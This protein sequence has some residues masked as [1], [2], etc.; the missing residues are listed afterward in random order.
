MRGAYII[1]IFGGMVVLLLIDHYFDLGLKW[2]WSIGAVFAVLGAIYTAFLFNQARG[3][4]LWQ[5]PW[6]GAIH[7][8]VH[9][10]IA[11]SVIMIMIDTGST[12]IMRNILYF[13]I[14]LNVFIILKEVFIPH[15]TPD[16]KKAI[17]M[18]TNGYYSRYFWSGVVLGSLLPFLILTVSTGHELV[19]GVMAL[20]GIFL[21]EFVRIRVP[22]MIPLS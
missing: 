18:M 5:T 11:G 13:S 2:A 10:I 19:A 7:M 16:S 1:T 21:T 22:Q 12:S 9:A 8:L 6:I 17:Q 14:L 15:D 4:D 3:R 20:I